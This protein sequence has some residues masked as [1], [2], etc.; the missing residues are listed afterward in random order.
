[1][2][3]CYRSEENSRSLI[4]QLNEKIHIWVRGLG[5]GRLGDRD[6]KARTCPGIFLKMP[7]KWEFEA[8][9][10]NGLINY[11]GTAFEQ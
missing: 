9:S 3:D 7:L 8:V 1:M 10:E 2:L 5:S 11:T 6:F 4:G